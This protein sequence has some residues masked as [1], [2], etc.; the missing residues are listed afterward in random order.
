MIY[1][2][3]HSVFSCSHCCLFTDLTDVDLF[4]MLQTLHKFTASVLV[5]PMDRYSGHLQILS[6][7]I[8]CLRIFRIKAFLETGSFCISTKLT[9]YVSCSGGKFSWLGNFFRKTLSEE[10]LHFFSLHG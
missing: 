10:N 4:W 9:F 3:A 7:S 5:C 1:S 8:Y 2:K 6:N